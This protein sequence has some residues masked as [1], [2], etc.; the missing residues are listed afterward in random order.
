MMERW[1]RSENLATMDFNSWS[2]SFYFFRSL[3]QNE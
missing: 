1:V 2:I 3:N